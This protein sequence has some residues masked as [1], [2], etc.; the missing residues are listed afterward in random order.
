MSQPA[1]AQ[2]ESGVT[3]NP[4]L[5]VLMSLANVLGV[6]VDDLLRLDTEETPATD[7]ESVPVQS[8]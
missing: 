8:A 7:A 5:D 6:K 1:I 4:T 2:I 3:R